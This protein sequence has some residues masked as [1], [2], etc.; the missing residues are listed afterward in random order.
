MVVRPWVKWIIYLPVNGICGW[1]AFT[2]AYVSLFAGATWDIV[3][4]AMVWL[5]GLG[6]RLGVSLLFSLVLRFWDHYTVTN[7]LLYRPVTAALNA[8]TLWAGFEYIVGSNPTLQQT[9]A[10]SAM[11]T[12]AVV[13]IGACIAS[14]VATAFS[15]RVTQNFLG[16]PRRPSSK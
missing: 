3:M 5:L 2:W 6:L 14:L 9:W 15:K 12:L 1:V 7:L 8:T 11:S 4:W 13:G 10:M 16:M